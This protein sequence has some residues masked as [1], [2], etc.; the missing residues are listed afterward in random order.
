MMRVAC[1]ALMGLQLAASPVAGEEMGSYVVTGDAIMEPLVGGKGDPAR[2]A[3]LI[4]DRQRSLCT[5]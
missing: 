3:T 5:L 2:G 1:L 4:S